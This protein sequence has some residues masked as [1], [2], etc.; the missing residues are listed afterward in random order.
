MGTV[1]DGCWLRQFAPPGRE[2]CRGQLVRA[3][4]IGR[5]QLRARFGRERGDELAQDPAT[6]V[7]A[8]GGLTGLEGHHGMFDHY[9]LRVPASALPAATVQ[10][11]ERYQLAAWLERHYG[12]LPAT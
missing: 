7:L 11:A 2:T 8:C 12:P 10:F 5:A 6:F 9:Q 1:L 4:V 3:H